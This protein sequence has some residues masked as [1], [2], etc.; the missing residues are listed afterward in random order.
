MF[1]FPIFLLAI[2]LM[3]LVSFVILH[4]FYSVCTY[5]G[6][7][8]IKEINLIFI[9]SHHVMLPHKFGNENGHVVYLALPFL[10]FSVP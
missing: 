2:S 5:L 6:Q 4:G 1:L 10:L 8:I 3:V 7:N 9:N